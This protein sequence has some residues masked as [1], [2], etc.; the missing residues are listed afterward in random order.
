MDEIQRGLLVFGVCLG[1]IFLLVAYCVV[2]YF[3]IRARVKRFEQENQD[4]D[5]CLLV[6]AETSEVVDLEDV[7]CCCR[8]CRYSSLACNYGLTNNESKFVVF[9]LGRR[10]KAFKLK[11]FR[12][13]FLWNKEL[14]Q[15]KLTDKIKSLIN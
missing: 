6:D 5:G 8:C 11:V 7:G 9:K 3:R 14:K 1:L 4:I 12:R 2:K 13:H 15:A 10:A